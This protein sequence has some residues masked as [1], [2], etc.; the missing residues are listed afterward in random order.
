MLRLADTTAVRS[1]R[2]RSRRTNATED[3]KGVAPWSR[4]WATKERS[5]AL[6]SPQTVSWSEGSLGSPQGSW[7]PRE[8]RKLATPS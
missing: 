6:P 3:G 7:M 4:R 8:A 2:S 1:P 5:L